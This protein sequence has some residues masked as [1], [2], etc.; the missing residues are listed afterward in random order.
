MTPT[1]S[2]NSAWHSPR[3]MAALAGCTGVGVYVLL[4]GAF[5]PVADFFIVNV[6]LPTIAACSRRHRPHLSWWFPS[7]VWL[8]PPCSSLGGRLGDRFGRHTL[9]PGR[10]CRLHPGVAGLRP[11]ADHRR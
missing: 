10:A 9:F 7:M 5:L 4:A 3:S 11:G 1:Y 8:M 6:A 2:P